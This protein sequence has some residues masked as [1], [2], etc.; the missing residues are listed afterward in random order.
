MYHLQQTISC[1][2]T[3]GCLNHINAKHY[4]TLSPMGVL[5][6]NMSMIGNFQF[7]MSTSHFHINDSLNT[8][9][10]NA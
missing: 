2:L 8:N 10:Y 9:V 1:I 4:P 7:M 5:V 3:D 6:I